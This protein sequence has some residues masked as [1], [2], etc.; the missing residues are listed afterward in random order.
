LAFQASTEAID[1]RA[2]ALKL[3]GGASNTP[4][5][6][7]NLKVKFYDA[8]N[9]S[10]SI[11]EANFVNEG[12]TATGT[13]AVGSFKVEKGYGARKILLIK[14]TIAD[15]S[16]VAYGNYQLTASGDL[17]KVDYDGAAVGLANG[18]Y[19]VGSAGNVSGPTTNTTLAGVRIMKAKPVFAKL[20]LPKNTIAGNADQS[21]YRFS[22]AAT[23]G[24]VDLYKVT[25]TV[26]SSTV[27]ATTSDYKLYAFTGAGFSGALP[28][29]ADST[30]LLNAGGCTD[31]LS[32][33]SPQRLTLNVYMDQTGC[34][35]GTTTLKIPMGSTY[36]FDLHA[37]FG[38]VRT[39]T[40]SENISFQL[41]GDSA[42]PVNSPNLM[43]Q[44]SGVDGD[45]S[46]DLI[47]SPRS[48]TSPSVSNLDFTNGNGV[49]GLPASNMNQETLTFT[50]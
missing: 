26:G 18:N 13:L 20:S 30:G 34:A 4:K 17:L 21:V 14:G 16:D 24:N 12:D 29:W 48:T 50:L 25:F 37:T 47:W 44:A 22:V 43:Q 27:S 11:G 49:D 15:I 10:V 2:V 46:D 3:T 39:T 23:N 31:G 6:L 8:A 36:Y 38:S 1:V 19:G 45:V 33:T 9:P 41:E 7:L 40:G 28:G 35:Q 42:F 5:D 32:D